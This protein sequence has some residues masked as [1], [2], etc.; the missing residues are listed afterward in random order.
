MLDVIAI[1]A[2][3]IGYWLARRRADPFYVH[4]VIAVVI[5]VLAMA[6]LLGMSSQPV[7]AD[8][9]LFSPGFL[10]AIVTMIWCC[11]IA[12]VGRLLRR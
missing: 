1:G 11:I 3:L 9:P 7:W 2:A 10:S 4:I 6:L 5:D 8:R 12:G